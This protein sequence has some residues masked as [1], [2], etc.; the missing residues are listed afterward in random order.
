MGEASFFYDLILRDPSL[1][2]G[3]PSEN[4][5]KFLFCPENLSVYFNIEP[6]FSLS[7]LREYLRGRAPGFYHLA[8]EQGDP[9]HLF[10]Q[11]L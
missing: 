5:E 6:N 9:I 3:Q 11:N 10:T 4:F 2:R 1:F 7:I 8:F